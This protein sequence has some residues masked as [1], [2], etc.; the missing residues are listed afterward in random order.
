MN[1]F[2]LIEKYFHNDSNKALAKQKRVSLGVGD[3][4]AVFSVDSGYQLVSSIDTLIAGVH[5]PSDCDPSDI[6]YKALSVN[7][8]DLAAMG[9]VPH[10]FT[11]SLTLPEPD[12]KWLQAFSETLFSLANQH[13]LILIGGDTV[14]GS[15]SL[16][17]QINGVVSERKFLRR[18]KAQEGDLLCVTGHLGL[19]AL[20]LK[21]WREGKQTSVEAGKRFLRPQARLE[22][23]NHLYEMGVR[24]A[25]DISDGLL[26]ELKH[27][28]KASGLSC[29]LN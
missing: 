10:S 6:A 9:A 20:G 27:L 17:I 2:S 25:I 28:C 13:E 19:A 14:K 11:L 23:A 22:F 16:S 1:E 5:F 26:S 29:E 15:L 4:A 24:S 21:E 3:D 18:D 7:L 8:S 12:E